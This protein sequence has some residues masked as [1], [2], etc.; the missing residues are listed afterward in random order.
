MRLEIVEVSCHMM[1]IGQSLVETC[2]IFLQA[3]KKGLAKMKSQKALKTGLVGSFLM[4]M[5]LMAFSNNITAESACV[6][7]EPS[8]AIEPRGSISYAVLGDTVKLTLDLEGEASGVRVSMVDVYY[9][10]RK[11]FNNWE[12]VE[13]SKYDLQFPL[14]L[15]NHEGRAKAEFFLKKK[16]RPLS[17]VITMEKQSDNLTYC[18]VK[19][20]INISQSDIEFSK[21]FGYVYLN[22]PD[23]K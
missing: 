11:L 16:F 6:R 5:V 7:V 3:I 10:L 2:T 23:N 1:E 22:N 13:S 21:K 8:S 20:V 14:G 9:G 18:D 17:L 12:E 15:V 4:S 19:Q